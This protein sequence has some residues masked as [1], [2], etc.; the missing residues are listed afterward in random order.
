MY[1]ENSSV[2]FAMNREMA[3][4]YNFALS[5]GGAMYFKNVTVA[6]FRGAA[7]VEFSNNISSRSAGGGMAFEN[8][9]RVEFTGITEM[10]FIKNTAGLGDISAN[11]QYGLGGAMY[12][13]KTLAT[14]SPSSLTFSLNTAKVYG[15][16]M[17]F[18]GATVTFNNALT[19]MTFNNNIARSG[20]GM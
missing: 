15:G 19:S 14:F 7:K 2:T 16:A 1:F 9:A 8:V 18:T 12:F 10:S 17:Y 11:A 4:R 20:G 3:F 5:S 6:I 13:N